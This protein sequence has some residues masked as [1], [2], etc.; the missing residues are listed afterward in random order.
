LSY[1]YLQSVGT[2]NV[3]PDSPPRTP[4][5]TYYYTAPANAKVVPPAETSNTTCTEPSSGGPL[6]ALALGNEPTTIGSTPD[7]NTMLA[8]QLI[9][10]G[11]MQLQM[12]R[13][14]F[15]TSVSQPNQAS[16]F[17]QA[18]NTTT[19]TP[20]SSQLTGVTSIESHRNYSTIEDFF[21]QISARDPKRDVGFIM[22]KL[23]EGGMLRIDEILWFREDDLREA[24]G[25]H[26]AEAKWLLREVSKAVAAENVADHTGC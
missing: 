13:N 26:L 25:L 19:N 23:L 7:L 21:R 22:D 5:Y 24:Y 12:F 17:P 14:M 15:G 4:L 8:M 6:P 18:S 9:S 3:G 20:A 16:P 11:Q 2:L 10:M 1:R